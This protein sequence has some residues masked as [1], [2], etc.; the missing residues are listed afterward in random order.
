MTHHPGCTP[1]YPEK[2]KGEKPQAMFD[3]N[4]DGEEFVRTCV[5]CGAFELIKKVYWNTINGAF[6]G[7]WMDGRALVCERKDEHEVPDECTEGP[8][9]TLRYAFG[10]PL[11]GGKENG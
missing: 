9:F 11:E 10:D 8:Q 1:N 6:H 5:D 4:I 3:L 7:L 2:K